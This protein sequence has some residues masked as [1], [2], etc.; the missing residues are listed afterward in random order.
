MTKIKKAA[1]IGVFRAIRRQRGL[2][3]T[4]T[5]DKAQT[6]SPVTRRVTG[7][8][9]EWREDRDLNPILAVSLRLKPAQS[10]ASKPPPFPL[11]AYPAQ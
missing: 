2:Q 6:K 5:H 10:V 1:G 4:D 7:L 8:F 9:Y 3:R 11:R